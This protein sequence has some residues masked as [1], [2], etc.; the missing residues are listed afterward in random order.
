MTPHVARDGLTEEIVAKHNTRESCWVVLYG[1]VYD[2]TDFLGSH[3]GGAKIILKLAGQDA[4]EEYD[5]IHPP[6]ILEEELKPEA[7]LGTIDPSTLPQETAP[8]P[9]Q[10]VEGPPPMENILNLDEMEEIAAKQISKKAWAYYYSASDDMFSKSFNNA[11]Y[12][13]ILLRPRVF[14][15]CTKCDLDTTVLGYN[16]KTPIYVSPAAMARLGHPSGE[17]GIAE[18]CRKFGAMQIISNNASMTPEQIV[19]DASPDQVFGW[20]LYAQIDRKKSEA[21]L[22]RINKLKAIKFIVLT[23]D[24]PIPGKRED[25]ERT[26]MTGRKAAVPSGIKAAER[27]ADDTPNPTEGSGG[28]G[29]QLFAGTDPS[30]TWTKTLAW[31]ATQTDLPII[32]KGL[33]THEDAYLASLHAPQVKGIILSNHGGRAMDTAP[34][35]VHTLLEI[36]K[37]C[38]EVF[39]KIEV[40][41]D[42]GIRRGTDAVKALC[43]GAKSV[44]LGR[45]ALYGLA[46]G[47]VEGVSRTLQS[48]LFDPWTGDLVANT[49]VVLNDEMKT[50]MRLLG[51]E[52]VD[53][54]G[55]QHVC[56][57]HLL[58]VSLLTG[59]QIN[60]R[61]TEQQIYDGPAA[62]EPLRRE[63]RSKL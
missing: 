48:K 34:P 18:A 39:D 61:V 6:G 20:Q 33:Q 7:C 26:G 29:Q 19:K 16:L 55:L 28:V 13:S 23:L 46:A 2:V 49:P 43:L 58:L 59:L 22:A 24:A 32:L 35:A 45:A 37:Y 63:F 8:E 42:G 9:E 10:E 50:C 4:T 52:R 51:V 53:Q 57:L 21:M 54:L 31:L 56:I 17:A 14:V 40:H 41:V 38:P 47:G 62:L 11:V 1:K 30:L 27:S 12:R 3:P 44:G 15:D 36:R 60:T 5:P 25:D